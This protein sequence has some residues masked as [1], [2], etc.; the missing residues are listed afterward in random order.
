MSKIIPTSS[1][2]TLKG[3]TPEKVAS[4]GIDPATLE[5]FT[6]SLIVDGKPLVD[7]SKE[8]KAIGKA[9]VDYLASQKN[10]KGVS[11]ADVFEQVHGPGY[12]ANLEKRIASDVVELALGTAPQTRAYKD[13]LVANTAL[14][15]SDFVSTKGKGTSTSVKA[16]P[17][18]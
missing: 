10:S 7:V 17:F 16:N 2:L 18:G 5:N 9:V 12:I 1:K 13:T 15:A 6:A 11:F 4:K 3:D 14:E 8:A